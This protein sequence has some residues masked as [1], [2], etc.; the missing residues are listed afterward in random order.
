VGFMGAGKS[1][2]GRALGERLNCEF[3]DLDD[4]IERVEGRSIAE[5]FRSS[6]EAEFRRAERTALQQVLRELGDETRIVGLGGGAF[7]AAENVARLEAAGVVTVFLDA[8]VEEL[9]R[10]C[11]KQAKMQGLERPLLQSIEQFQEL[12]DSRRTSYSKASLRV[13]TGNRTVAEIAAEIAEA[14]GLKSW[15][16]EKEKK[17]GS[18]Q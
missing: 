1:S 5:I 7:V 8:P 12:L 11:V 16:F 3:E 18:P 4:R 9:W 13:T 10:R 2:V 17:E 15:Q 6:G 14:I